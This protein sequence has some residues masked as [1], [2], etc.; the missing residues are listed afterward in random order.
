M[1][2]TVHI[3]PVNRSIY[4]EAGSTILDAALVHGIDYPHGCRSGNCGACKSRL[5]SG[6]DV[7]HSPYSPFAL[8]AYEYADGLIL[9]CRA[10][11]WSDCEVSWCELDENLIHPVRFMECEVASI[12]RL[13]HDIASLKLRILGGGPFAFSPGQFTSLTFLGMPRREY[14]IASFENGTTLEYYIRL[15]KGGMASQYVFDGLCVGD[16]LT[17]EGP[18][19]NM[20]FR[21]DHQGDIIALAGGSG[22]SA[23]QPIVMRALTVYSE[24]SV[25]LYHGMRSENDLYKDELFENLA[26]KHQNFNYVPV[27]SDEQGNTNRRTGMLHEVVESDLQAVNH[28]KAYLAGPPPMVSS[29]VDVLKQKGISDENIHADPFLTEADQAVF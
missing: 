20:Y 26:E 14:S 29:C 24:Q 16:L 12:T 21:E 17:A 9:A 19:G 6:D 2:F 4:V 27:L 10:V 23:I 8:S 22:L 1:E 13:T 28:F 15:I 7:E 11:P 3:R 5:H 18:F 25:T